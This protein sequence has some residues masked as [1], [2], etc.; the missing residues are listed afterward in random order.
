MRPFGACPAV[1]YSI[2]NVYIPLPT[3]QPGFHRRS[4][5]HKRSKFRYPPNACPP[6]TASKR[7]HVLNVT[8]RSSVPCGATLPMSLVKCAVIHVIPLPFSFS[9]FSSV[10]LAQ[11]GGGHPQLTALLVQYHQHRPCT[12]RPLRHGELRIGA[13]PTD[14]FAKGVKRHRRSCF[15]VHLPASTTGTLPSVKSAWCISLLG[16]SP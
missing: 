11:P 12:R 1:L 13:D 8:F 6:T 4:A 2:A 14:L 10:E 3:N 9:V 16:I 5:C 15:L 7:R